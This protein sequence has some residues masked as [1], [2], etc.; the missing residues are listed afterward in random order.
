MPIN[1]TYL[2][3]FH[4]VAA[5]GGFSKAA[6]ALRVAQPTLSQQVNALETGYDAELFERRGRGVQ[7]T[8]FGQELF[9]ITNRLFACASEAEEILAGAHDLTGGH[10]LL[11][12]SGSHQIVPLMTAFKARFPEPRVS[13]FVRNGDDLIDALHNRHIDI[14]VHSDPPREPGLGR[15]LIKV[16]S[17]VV[18]VPVGH[19]FASRTSVSL[20]EAVSEPLILREEGTHIRKLVGEALRRKDLVPEQLMDVGDWESIRELVTEGHGISIMS[21]AD[22]GRDDRV[23]A[24]PL[25]DP[26]LEVSE[27]LVYFKERRRLK[28]VRAFL[29]MAENAVADPS[30]SWLDTRRTEEDS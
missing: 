4:A 10:L 22:A 6:R 21:E 28:V 14:A 8:T 24:I 18:L 11:G 1:F 27:Y 16:D 25:R 2:R 29:E 7:L 17:V 30:P 3:A 12:A 20:K 23:V 19:P 5:E 13:L 26:R 15:T 9:D